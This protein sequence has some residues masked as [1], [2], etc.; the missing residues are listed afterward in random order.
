MNEPFLQ[1]ALQL[2]L[3]RHSGQWRD[4]QTPL[5]YVFHPIGVMHNLIHTGG[6][7][8]ESILAAALLHDLVEET[9]TSILEIQSE[10]GSRVAELVR[11]VT[12]IEPTESERRG[13]TAEEIWELR[14]NRL[15]AEISAMS[16]DAQCIKL[17]DRLD[18]LRE[19][20]ATR[21]PKKH[22][23]YLRQ[24]I[25]IL[26]IIPEDVNKPLWHAVEGWTKKK[27]GRNC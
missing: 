14:T 2:A 13:L 26:A 19:S 17:A 8:D 23:R 10:F 12:R 7:R 6:I 4:G 16:T 15:L 22:E 18:N 25:R 21:S 9:E 1:R 24:T 5:P 3:E 20:S 27:T 11:E